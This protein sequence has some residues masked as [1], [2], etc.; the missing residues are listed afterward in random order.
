[1]R[2]RTDNVGHNVLTTAAEVEL[3]ALCVGNESSEDPAVNVRQRNATNVCPIVR[4][5][6]NLQRI[7][8]S[9]GSDFAV[10]HRCRVWLAVTY[11][12]IYQGDYY[13]YS[14]RNY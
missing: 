6:R 3:N 9:L 4:S 5:D 12:G 11:L 8:S 1:M 10:K 7:V 14:L 2:V 13:D